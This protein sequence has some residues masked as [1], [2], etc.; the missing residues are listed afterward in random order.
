MHWT[1]Y[2]G[3][4]FVF[5]LG[6]IRSIISYFGGRL[7]KLA[8]LKLKIQTKTALLFG[9]PFN[10]HTRT[11]MHTEALKRTDRSLSWLV[12]CCW[13]TLFIF[14]HVYKTWGVTEAN[15]SLL[16]VAI[17][18]IERT[19][20]NITKR[21]LTKITHHAFFIKS[22]TNLEVYAQA[23]YMPI[24]QKWCAYLRFFFSDLL[25]NVLMVLGKLFMSFGLSIFQLAKEYKQ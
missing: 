13:S 12:G 8:V 17:L 1:S 18:L 11:D 5:Y 3:G 9:V 25:K 19:A 4:L 6:D 24:D 16:W 10:T 20:P 2:K 14:R 7:L 22:Y 15:V 23:K 21:A